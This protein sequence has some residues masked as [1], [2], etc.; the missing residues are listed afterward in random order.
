M[1]PD[2]IDSKNSY[3]IYILKIFAIFTIFFAHMPL[4][5]TT[6]TLSPHFSWLARLYALLGMIGV[7]VF[8]F[9]SGY[10]YKKGSLKKRAIALI[11]PLLIW[12]SLTYL[13]HIAK[14]GIGSFSIIN[15][16]LWLVG[17]NCYL[18]FVTILFLIIVLYHFY[19][20]N[21]IYILLGVVCIGLYESHLLHYSYPL[22]PYLNPLN[23]IIYFALGH[24]I[25]QNNLWRKISN[26]NALIGCLS[27]VIIVCLFLA[28]D[29]WIHVWYFDL[30]SVPVNVL[31]ILLCVNLTG[32]IH[33]IH[34][35]AIS[36]GKCTYVIYLSH[37]P[38][39]TTLNKVI[40]NYLNGFS[41][42]LKVVIA[43]AIVVIAV[44]ILRELLFKINKIGLMKALGYRV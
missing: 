13:L 15:Y 35:Q 27:A 39:A 9:L 22:T 4:S 17:S 2:K 40:P 23:F 29:F 42:T 16:F 6:L 26:G 28:K 11:I 24:L 38:I 7:P 44:V 1:Q 21:Y 20:N 3:Q 14:E 33:N 18:Y 25:R 36:I 30:I 19:E 12:G 43:F 5:D 32:I 8:M 37:M 31:V 10:L 34:T 41:E